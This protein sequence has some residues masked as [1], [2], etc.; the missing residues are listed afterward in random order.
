VEPANRLATPTMSAQSLIDN[1]AF[2]TEKRMPVFL[3]GGDNQLQIGS[4][5]IRIYQN[6]RKIM[7]Y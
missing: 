3:N 6:E 1:R 2:S 5:H 4:I 7:C